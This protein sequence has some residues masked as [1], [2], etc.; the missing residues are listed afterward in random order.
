MISAVIIK[1]LVK[2]GAKM[3]KLFPFLEGMLSAM[4][5]LP[6]SVST[7]PRYIRPTELKL[8]DTAQDWQAVGVDISNASK[9]VGSSLGMIRYEPKTA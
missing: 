7:E 2:Q 1:C 9:K 5:L 3:S 4:V 6:S 8:S